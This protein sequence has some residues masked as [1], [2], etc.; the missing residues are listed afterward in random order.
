MS[1]VI[2]VAFSDLHI[3]LWNKFNESNQRTLNHFRVLLLVKQACEKHKVPALFMGDMFHKPEN[4]DNELFDITVSEL[5]KLDGDWA[6]YAISGNHDMKYGN[7]PDKP[8]PS[9]VVSLAKVIP[10]LKCVDFKRK[11]LPGFNLYGVP[12]LEHNIGLTE[13]IS[14][15]NRSSSKPNILMLHT[16]YPG[17]LDTDGSEVGSVEN[18]NVNQLNK[19]DLTLIGHIHNPQRVAKKVYMVGAT[20]QQR[21]TDR[22]CELGYWLIKSDL[23]LEFIS[24]NNLLPRFI[25][26]EDESEIKDDGNYYTVLPKKVELKSTQDNTITKDLSKTRIAKQYI[27][28]V[29]IEDRAKTRLLI[30]ILKQASDD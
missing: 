16:D 28:E 22:D 25:D 27:K 1:K 5:R 2:A 12:Y 4:I 18:L 13:T 8:S 10:W 3:S 11:V 7:K 9:F 29:G 15:F 6:C 17:A 21:R 20:H 24:L 30:R 14:K 19:F 23:T 26:V